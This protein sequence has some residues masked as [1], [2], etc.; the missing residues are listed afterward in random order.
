MATHTEDLT[1]PPV[2]EQLTEYQGFPIRRGELLQQQGWSTVDW[3]DLRD[4]DLIQQS[5][6]EGYSSISIPDLENSRI[7][8][9][10]PARTQVI[11][12]EF[13]QP[14]P[15]D[16]ISALR[17]GG[18][19][20]VSFEKVSMRNA[21]FV[22][23]SDLARPAIGTS[24]M[25]RTSED[26]QALWSNYPSE[27]LGRHDFELLWHAPRTF[28]HFFA[29]VL[30]ELEQRGAWELRVSKDDQYEYVRE[31]MPKGT[32]L[33]KLRD[34]EV[35]RAVLYYPERVRLIEYAFQNEE[36]SD[37]PIVQQLQARGWIYLNES[38]NYVNKA[39][40]AVPIAQATE[41]QMG[42]NVQFYKGKH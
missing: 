32:D 11:S 37:S 36:D 33:V 30:E 4:R 9:F 7:L 39:L 23:S 8:I 40:F 41:E 20:F 31:N 29:A 22:G 12:Y 15:R 5:V 1:A 19:H 26:A 34:G 2:L 24:T 17:E 38:P 42:S 6:P 27:P 14:M 35:I 16:E 28:S 13:E 25:V 18:W 21:I 3:W 10:D